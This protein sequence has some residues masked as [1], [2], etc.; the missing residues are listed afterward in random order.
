MDR[1]STNLYSGPWSQTI[2]FA[3][4][5]VGN[6]T[7]ANEQGPTEI[8]F[9]LA[10]Q[11][12]TMSR[13]GDIVTHTYDLNGNLTG[14]RGKLLSVNPGT[15]TMVYD[16]ENRMVAYNLNGTLTT[17]TYSADGLKRAEITSAGTTTLVWDGTDYLQERT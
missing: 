16:K 8:S 15:I 17:Y 3:Y 6:R 5:A 11:I 10:G 7:Y 1:I 4:D 9:D 2:T 12:V 13:E 14:V